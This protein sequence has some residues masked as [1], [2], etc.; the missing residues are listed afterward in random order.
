MKKRNDK[1]EVL[2]YPKFNCKVQ[3]KEK[4]KGREG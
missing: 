1:E 3:R 4:R 2:G